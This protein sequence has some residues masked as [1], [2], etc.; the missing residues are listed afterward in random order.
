MK[1]WSP[2]FSHDF[3]GFSLLRCEYLFLKGIH[4]CIENPMSTLLWTYRPME[5]LQMEIG[6]SCFFLRFKISFPIHFLFS[7]PGDAPQAQVQVNLSATRSPGGEKW[8]PLQQMGCLAISKHQHVVMYV[9]FDWY[10]YKVWF[11]SVLIQIWYIQV[12]QCT[13]SLKY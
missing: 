3:D 4:Y 11:L 7:L 6:S 5:A 1:P 9:S 2:N 8:E 12:Y 10:T 13:R